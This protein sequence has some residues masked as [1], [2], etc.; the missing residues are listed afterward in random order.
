MISLVEQSRPALIEI[1][2]RFKVRRLYIF[3]SAVSDDFKPDS[4]DLDFLVDLAD[5][6]PTQDY[7]D[8][9][10]G[11]ADS[12]EVLFRRPVDLLTEQ[13]LRNPYLRREVQVTRE[14]VYEDSRT[15]AAV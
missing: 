8:R 2:R 14:L 7:A 10:L 12:L 3:G 4:S 11:L 15:E 5:R 6:E 9:Y 1:C 13:S